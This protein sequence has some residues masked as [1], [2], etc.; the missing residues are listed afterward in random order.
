[1]AVRRNGH[2]RSRAPHPDLTKSAGHVVES[3]KELGGDAR[4]LAGEQVS[5]ARD[6]AADYWEDGRKRVVSWEES[7]EEMIREQPVKSMLIAAGAGLVLGF[8]FRRR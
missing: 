6:T 2:A 3:I 1:M 5:H 7:L 8:M 4:T